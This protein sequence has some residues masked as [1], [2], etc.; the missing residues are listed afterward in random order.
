MTLVKYAVPL[1]IFS[2]LAAIFLLGVRAVIVLSDSM[3]P[4]ISRGSLVITA[5][6]N[7]YNVGDIILFRILERPVLHRIIDIDEINGGYYRTKGDA[8]QSIDPLRVPKDA[9]AG[10]AI[11]TVP[12]FRAAI[13]S[14][15]NPLNLAL[16]AS[17]T[18]FI[19]CIILIL[20]KHPIGQP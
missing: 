15:R 20:L 19:T 3:G 11:L 9:V 1:S 6:S 7:E 8:S 5:P 12:G 10:K 17:T 18:Y 2:I 4:T 14:L 16:I 13:N